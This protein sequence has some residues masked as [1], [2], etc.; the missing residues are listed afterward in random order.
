M[1]R[2][3]LNT[4]AAAVILL[5]VCSH[6][7]L[8]VSAQNVDSAK[9]RRN[10]EAAH[11][12]LSRFNRWPQYLENY[13]TRCYGNCPQ[14]AGGVDL[15]VTTATTI[16]TSM[17]SAATP[18]PVISRSLGCGV[19]NSNRFRI[20]GGTDT[21]ECEFPWVVEVSV[22]R[23]FCGGTI[24]DQRHILTAAHC[25]KDRN[26]GA[27]FDVSQVT[28]RVGSSQLSRL[29]VYRVVSM[30]LDTR[31][32]RVINDYDVAVLTLESD[33]TFSDCVYPICLPDT[34]EEASSAEFC[35]AAGW[36][37]DRPLSQDLMPVLQKVTLPIVANS[38]CAQSYGDRYVNEL[39][40]CAGNFNSGGIDTCQGDSGGPLFCKKNNR[41]TIFGIVSF[42]SGC[43]RAGYPGVYTKV[44]HQLILNFIQQAIR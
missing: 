39:K 36:G 15:T 11:S 9:C 18:S 29:R 37:V 25:L 17:T 12:L 33:L 20:V 30:N 13:L 5:A 16:R 22:D 40:V 34:W 6:N 26:S 24:L 2:N 38:L 35:I 7:Q 8:E 44:S 14:A 4:I 27:I 31:H 41:Y 23:L 43:A 32:V 3:G 28:V 1:S 21:E 42:G 19:Q 10:C